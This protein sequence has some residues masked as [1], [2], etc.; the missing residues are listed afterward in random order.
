VFLAS[1][2]K[3]CPPATIRGARLDS[4]YRAQWFDP[5][6]GTWSDVGAGELQADTIGII[7]LPPFPGDTDWGLRLVYEGRAPR[8]GHD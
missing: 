3:G 5:R 4:D 6:D 8:P 2:E 7:T 1:F